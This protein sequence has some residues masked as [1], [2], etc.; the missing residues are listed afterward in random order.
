[1]FYSLQTVTGVVRFLYLFRVFSEQMSYCV[2]LG[3]CFM[4]AGSIKVGHPN[5]SLQ[6]TFSQSMTKL[7]KSY[8]PFLKF[9]FHYLP[10]HLPFG[11]KVNF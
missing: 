1:M 8:V 6:S 11:L 3:E 4:Q 7:F 10:T 5:V 9:L 2:S